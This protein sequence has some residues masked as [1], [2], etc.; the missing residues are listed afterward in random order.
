MNEKLNVGDIVMW[1]PKG[2]R[3]YICS[4]ARTVPAE[5]GLK[6]VVDDRRR[7]H[8]PYLSNEEYEELKQA[9]WYEAG[10]PNAEPGAEGIGLIFSWYIM[11]KSKDVE[12]I[13]VWREQ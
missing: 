13:I 12:G 6:P 10:R 2:K 9:E 1:T 5:S 11:Q 8:Y 4:V 7:A 3:P